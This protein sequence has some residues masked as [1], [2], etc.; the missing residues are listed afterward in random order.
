MLVRRLTH[1][2]LVSVA[3][4]VCVSAAAQ[5]PSPQTYEAGFGAGRDAALARDGQSPPRDG[6]VA[7]RKG[8][9]RLAGRVIGASGSPVRLATLRL[10]APA[11][12]GTAT[13][14]SDRDGR[15]EFP[16]LPAGRYTVSASRDGFVS[17]MI[18]QR[19]PDAQPV[20]IDVADAQS[21]E[22]PDLVLPRGSVI[23]GRIL[24]E[25]GEPLTEVPV[26]ALQRRLINGRWRFLN[27][28][29]RAVV[30]NDV[31]EFRLYGLK[32]GRYYVATPRRRLTAGSDET[33]A[34]WGY[35]ETYYPGTASSSDAQAVAVGLGETLTGVDFTL[36]PTRLVT[37]SGTAINGRGEP[38]RFGVVTVM[39]ADGERWTSANNTA[40]IL[41][42]GTFAVKGL[43]PGSY[44]L[45][46]PIP[47]DVGRSLLPVSRLAEVDYVTATVDVN[48]SDIGGVVLQ[49]R[50]MLT[51]SGRMTTDAPGAPLRTAEPTVVVS[52]LDADGFSVTSRVAGDGTFQ[53]TVPAAP[54]TIKVE[55]ASAQWAVK[56]VK[57]S[58]VDITDTGVDLRNAGDVVGVAVTIT[59]RPQELSGAVI[60]P[61][62]NAV[63]GA[64]VLIFPEERQRWLFGTR[65]MP[66]VRADAQGGYALSSLP[67][68]RYLAAAFEFVEPLVP[69]D[70]EFLENLRT[71]AIGF[72][73]ADGEQKTLTLSLTADR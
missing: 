10:A 57:V 33:E 70:P 31:G 64:T 71:R 60:R 25:F 13:T 5:Q 14:T 46:M 56:A 68:G 61:D 62:G 17:M 4:C 15:Y 8:T 66:M 29:G 1:V 58:G 6:K 69:N 67:P 3:V 54:M 24:D 65:L 32:P 26:N 35:S 44:M 72:S 39:T 36:V 41:S 23:T 21:V 63:P 50:R 51:L 43:P 28:T 20:P 55:L 22:A 37:V 12:G 45:R 19:R 59:N 53:L 38:L 47:L 2:F 48:G 52:T 9:S 18:G 7:L 16:D 42:D 40:S 27:V 73:L 34:V 11:L 49:P 30:T